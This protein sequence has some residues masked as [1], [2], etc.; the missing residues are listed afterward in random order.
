MSTER[1][2]LEKKHAALF[3]ATALL[4][5]A[6]ALRV[7]AIDAIPPGL[8][9]DEV[10]QLDVARQ[11]AAGDWRLLYPGGFAE[12]G[13]EAGYHPFLAA[14]ELSVGHNPLAWRLP[15]IFG[16]M[17]GLACLY[18]LAARLFNRRVA[19]IA[20]GVAAVTWWH[21]L[22]S[23]VILREVLEIPLYVGVVRVLARL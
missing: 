18:V 22:L 15:A 7:F 16:G 19:L 6:F 9:H 12:D 21:I 20:L 10:S 1:S 13:A 11:M 4:L 23:R 17:I 14:A 3:S 5:L 8:T 2:G